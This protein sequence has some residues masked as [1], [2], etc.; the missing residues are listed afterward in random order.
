MDSTSECHISRLPAEILQLIVDAVPEP[1]YHLSPMRLVCKDFEAAVFEEWAARWFGHLYCF[2]LD[3]TRLQRI[4]SITSHPWF[5]KQIASIQFCLDPWEIAEQSDISIANVRMPAPLQSLGFEIVVEIGQGRVKELHTVDQYNEF[6]EPP[7]QM[8]LAGIVGNLGPQCVVDLDLRMET[9]FRNTKLEE[10]RRDVVDAILGGVRFPRI[11]ELV[12]HN[13]ECTFEV[14][15]DAL[16]DMAP[17]IE[18]VYLKEFSLKS[19]GLEDVPPDGS[20]WAAVFGVML[21]CPRL[22]DL[23]LEC[24]HEDSLTVAELVEHRDSWSSEN[25]WLDGREEIQE[26]LRLNIQYAGKL[27]GEEE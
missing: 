17:T 10:R 13:A 21:E 3:P 24:V 26:S 5:A 23:G 20:R 25:L 8:L 2:M 22:D 16:R 9:E 15:L 18:E 27:F 1:A 19:P 11:R 12:V 7:D 4:A 14:F 6:C